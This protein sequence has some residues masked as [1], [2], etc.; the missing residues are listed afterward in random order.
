LVADQGLSIA[1]Q[2]AI[3]LW[4]DART[5]PESAR[6]RDLLRDKTKAVTGFFT[7]VGKH[8]A[9][10]TALD[11][12]AWQ[13][14][15]ERSGL[16]ASTIY[17]RISRVSSFYEW[18]MSDPDLCQ[19]ILRNPVQLARP[20]AP[21]AYQ[22]ESTQALSDEEVKA[23]L[24]VVKAKADAD[25]IVGKR[26]YALLLFFFATGMRR[27][28]VMRLRW[29]DVRINDTVTV[30]ARV[31]G[32]DYVGR[33]IADPRVRDALLNY[34]KVSSRL[35]T[36]DVETPLWTSH[37]R[38]RLHSDDQLTGHAFAKRLKMYARWAGLGDVHLHQ[39]RHTF[40]RWVSE[41]TGS[42]IETQ[43]ALGHKHAATTRV[44]VQR[45]AVKKDRHSTSILDRLE[46]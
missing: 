8:P 40:A 19:E 5:D 35:C 43:D 42:I 10:V 1:L 41:S 45:V 13:T 39:T 7:Y 33:E 23:L 21:R 9:Q 32:G 36:M 20:K 11:V 29:G 15:M 12:K 37:D 22:T 34:L 14:E 6:R 2:N 27:S 31:K 17:A 4:A 28:E 16:S 3:S 30:T 44:Y 18:A 25:D 46:V 38:T 24:A 26:D